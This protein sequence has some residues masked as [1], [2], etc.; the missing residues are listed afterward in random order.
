MGET[1]GSEGFSASATDVT[2][3]VVPPRGIVL[4]VLRTYGRLFLL[5][6]AG[7]W[8]MN[9]GTLFVGHD[10]LVRTR[11][12]AEGL[13][14]G[15]IES[16]CVGLPRYPGE[17]LVPPPAL[18]RK[19]TKAVEAPR[20]HSLNYYHPEPSYLF[21]ARYSD[22][23]VVAIPVLVRRNKLVICDYAPSNL[24][25]CWDITWQAFT[26]PLVPLTQAE[27]KWLRAA[28][29]RPVPAW[30]KGRKNGEGVRYDRSQLWCQVF[31][32]FRCLL[33]HQQRFCWCARP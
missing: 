20:H 15:R 2:A 13:H 29:K 14:R 10:Q 5:L 33:L 32:Y 7:I 11:L 25:R 19:F 6:V 18:E 30:V 23:T 24:N 17:W 12:L 26:S 21:K 22:G 9:F 31:H 16:V 1:K 28:K 8:G 4:G 27:M 3:A